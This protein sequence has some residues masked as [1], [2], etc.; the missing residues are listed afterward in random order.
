MPLPRRLS[1]SSVSAAIFVLIALVV[2]LLNDPP[3]VI[4]MIGSA[5][6]FGAVACLID[7]A[8]VFVRMREGK[9][10]AP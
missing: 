7:A 9:S 6:A 5:A 1:I 2:Y 3:F 10:T 8:I 4:W